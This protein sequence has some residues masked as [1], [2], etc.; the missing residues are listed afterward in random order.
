[1]TAVEILLVVASGYAAIWTSYVLLIPLIAALRRWRA[2][3]TLGTLEG[4]SPTIAIIVPAHDM[5]QIIARC[6]HSLQ[7]CHYPM[8]K[9]DIY[10]VADHC[11]DDTAA[12]AESEGA[13]VLVR[14]DGPAGKTYALS[15]TLEKLAEMGYSPDLY[16]ITDATARV[17]TG[18]LDAL[19]DGYRQGEDI[20]VSHPVV[21]AENQKWFA[22]C[23]GLTLVHRN[24]Q[25][26]ARQQLGLSSLIEGRGMAY[27]KK[28]VERYGWTLALPKTE[29]GSTH[30]TE[31]WRHGVQAVE[32]GLR[33]AFADSARVITPL[34]NTLA[35]ATKQ[36]ARWERGRMANAATHAM[37]LLSRGF[38]ERNLVKVLAALDAIQPPVAILGVICIGLF[39]FSWLTADT[40]FE[41]AFG[42]APVC[43]F[44]FYGLIVVAQG[45]KDG[46]SPVTVLWAPVYLAWRCTSFVLAWGFF[47]RFNIG[48]SKKA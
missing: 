1:M 27:S 12:V 26:W 24:L 11:A 6:I 40:R 41:L 9:V 16:I 31:D 42:I 30:P 2:K 44:F 35:A 19:V 23:L 17:E 13:T 33:V 32:Q 34:R 45:R 20:V 18:F 4:N 48:S 5:A 3:P 38:R 10:V 29:K 15:W 46:I 43:A 22:R 14:N 36:G 47:D 39:I 21:D 8:D 37:R 28:Y 25:N 7:A